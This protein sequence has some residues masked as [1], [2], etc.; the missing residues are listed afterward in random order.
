[1]SRSEPTYI[2]PG[3]KKWVEFPYLIILRILN[4]CVRTC[5]GVGVCV[6]AHART[7]QDMHIQILENYFASP[8]NH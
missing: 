7:T 4:V 6:H 8:R 5:V 1:M 2:I 3:D